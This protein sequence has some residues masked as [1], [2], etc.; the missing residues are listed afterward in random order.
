MDLSE[1]R[2]HLSGLGPD[3]HAWPDRDAALDLLA[4]SDDAVVPRPRPARSPLLRG[5][6][7]RHPGRRA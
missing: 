4:R 3:I 2:R 5:G 7:R 6:D 1:F